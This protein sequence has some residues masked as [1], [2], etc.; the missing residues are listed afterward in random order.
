[1]LS[2]RPLFF[3][4]SFCLFTTA[5]GAASSGVE[6]VKEYLVTTVGKMKEASADLK[7]NAA[8]FQAIIAKNGGDYKK[9]A[10]ADGTKLQALVKAM[11]ENYKAIDSFGYE[12]VEGIVAGVDELADYD[13]YLDAGVPEGEGAPDEVAQVTLQLPGGGKID[14]KGAL[15]T[16]I[17]EPSLWG[18][19]PDFVVAVDGAATLPKAEVL[20]AASTDAD[21]KIGKLLADSK[22]WQP[23]N[24]DCFGALVLMTPTLSDYFED[25]KESRFSEQKSGRFSAVSRISD[26]RGIMSSC[27]IMYDAVNAP[28][29]A[30]D[31]AL[32]RA[33]TGGFREIL[34]FLDTIESREKAGEIKAAEVDEMAAQAKAKTDKLVP[35]I[36]QA[37]V[38]VDAKPQ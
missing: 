30:K 6:S 24:S 20:V 9:A 21:E 13:V 33:I 17:I 19:A 16:Y 5:Q 34:A 32:S 26:M 15:F 22:A 7:K 29:A 14:K 8:E 23:S 31:E 25:W 35:Q 2:V 4:F 11:Q 38:L 36:E 28:V 18:T 12:T 37:S 3:A 10:A 1:M 27:S